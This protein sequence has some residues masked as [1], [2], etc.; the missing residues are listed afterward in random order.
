MGKRGKKRSSFDGTIEEIY[1]VQHSASEAIYHVVM[2]LPPSLREKAFALAIQRV[3]SHFTW[4]RKY[5]RSI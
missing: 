5:G 2:A 1:D 3:T 4:E